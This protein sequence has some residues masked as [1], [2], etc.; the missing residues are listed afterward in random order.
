MPE[1]WY[2]WRVGKTIWE[3]RYNLVPVLSSQVGKYGD[4]MTDETIMVIFVIFVIT[5]F[6]LG[7]IFGP[8]IQVDQFCCQNI[9]NGVSCVSGYSCESKPHDDSD[10][11][12]DYW[13]MSNIINGGF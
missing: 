10:L 3:H 12:M 6:S 13:Y 8:H 7:I 9:T 5:V 2:R 11:I 1:M 4:E